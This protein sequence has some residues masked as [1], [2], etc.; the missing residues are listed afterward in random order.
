MEKRNIIEDGR[1][2]DLV[3]QAVSDTF[4]KDAVQLFAATPKVFTPASQPVKPE[5]AVSVPWMAAA[6]QPEA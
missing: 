4:E 6:P 3:K 5:P 1:T 2:P